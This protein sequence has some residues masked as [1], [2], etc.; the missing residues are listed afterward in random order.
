MLAESTEKFFTEEAAWGEEGVEKFIC[1]VQS[2]L[3][4]HKVQN[5][6]NC[7]YSFYLNC[8]P[9]FLEHLC[10]YD[11][12]KKRNQVLIELYDRFKIFL[13]KKSYSFDSEDNI[14]LLRDVEGNYFARKRFEKSENQD[15]CTLLFEILEEFQNPE[16]NMY[17]KEKLFICKIK[18]EMY[19]WR[20]MK[21][22]GILKIS[23]RNSDN[24]FAISQFLENW[25]I[26]IFSNIALKSNCQGS[27]LVRKKN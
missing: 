1:A 22:I 10:S 25:I 2:Q 21:R 6:N 24:L 16:I 23:K 8:G 7:C 12:A 14:L 4:L 18:L 17:W 26:I 20:A 13:E 19:Y 5:K 11:T 15:S 9:D 3:G 27:M